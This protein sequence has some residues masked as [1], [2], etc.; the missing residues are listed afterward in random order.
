MRPTR[1]AKRQLGILWG[2]PA[3]D[4]TV[5]TILGRD[6][7]NCLDV[8]VIACHKFSSVRRSIKQRYYRQDI[9]PQYF[10]N[11][12]LELKGREIENQTGEKGEH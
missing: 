9:H 2:L 4:I 8:T 11:K 3:K 12:G 6:E 10:A 5:E 1:E 7:R